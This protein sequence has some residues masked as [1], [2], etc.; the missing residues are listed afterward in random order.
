MDVTELDQMR[1]KLK[2]SGVKITVM[3]ILIKTISLALIE[4]PKINSLYRG[5]KD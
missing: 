5:E 1:E 2:K 4:N 3:G